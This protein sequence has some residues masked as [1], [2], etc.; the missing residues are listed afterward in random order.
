MPLS[1]EQ[2]QALD[3]L[4][5]P[6]SLDRLTR[7]FGDLG[8]QGSEPLGTSGRSAQ[9]LA[10]SL[11]ERA[12]SHSARQTSGWVAILMDR[13]QI[14][15]GEI[16]E[17]ALWFVRRQ[18]IFARTADFTERAPDPILAR[19]PAPDQTLA[20]PQATSPGMAPPD[21]DGI[22][23]PPRRMTLRHQA[24]AAAPAVA[25]PLLDGPPDFAP[26]DMTG[27][28]DPQTRRLILQAAERVMLSDYPVLPLY[29]FVSKRL[30]KPYVIGVQPNPLDSLP[31][32]ALTL[33]PH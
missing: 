4:P 31:S 13:Y 19:H 2:Q 14:K 20:R 25:L 27:T 15:V 18:E 24:V 22:S 29:Y 1:K 32:K 26:P 16:Q 9:S 6:A 30:V 21:A 33:V 3:R 5:P 8:A 23:A 10:A 7:F 28:P 12:H 17:F 11:A